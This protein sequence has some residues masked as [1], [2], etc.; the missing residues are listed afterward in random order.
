[1]TNGNMLSRSD[2]DFGVHGYYR[3]F[4]ALATQPF[5]IMDEPASFSNDQKA[6]ERI[7]EELKPQC[8]VRFGAYISDIAVGKGKNKQQRKIISIFCMTLNAC[9][10]FNQNLIKGVAVKS[11]LNLIFPKM[12]K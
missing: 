8:I 12:R 3:P 5:V 4:D 9:E 10:S 11:I 2:Y 1:M 7:V 6:Y